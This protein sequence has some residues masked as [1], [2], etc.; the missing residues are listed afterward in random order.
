MRIKP[1]SIKKILCVRNDRFGEFLLNIPAFRALKQTYPQAKIIAVIDPYLKDLT[2]NIPLIDE[3]IAWKGLK[4]S[5]FDKL[6]LANLL[7]KKNIDVAVIFNPSKEFNIITYLSGIPVRVGYAKKWGFLLT[8]TLKDKKYLGKKHEIEYNLELVGLIGAETED[9]TLSLNINSDIINK[10]FEAFKIKN[11]DVLV[12]LHPWTSDSVKLWAQENFVELAKRLAGELNIKVLIVGGIEELSKSTK[13]FK[14]EDNLI[15]LTGKTTLR[16][17][18]AL[19]KRC[20]LLISGDSGPVHLASCV[21]VPVIAIF[22]N[23]LP[24]KTAQRWGPWGDRNFVIEKPK[25]AEITVD[26]VATKAREILER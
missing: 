10:L 11:S 17:L 21:N 23:D 20:K 13:L 2:E 18:G 26:E 15:N 6:K 8:H 9:K 7:K 14:E 12:A 5:F 19:L 24:G 3:V 25:L 16:E 1:E 4:H 22:R